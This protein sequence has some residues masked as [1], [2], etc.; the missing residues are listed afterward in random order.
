VLADT[1]AEPIYWAS[2]ARALRIR[3]FIPLKELSF[4][5]DLFEEEKE[6]E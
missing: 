4:H 3:R 2:L 1:D 5:Q 6:E